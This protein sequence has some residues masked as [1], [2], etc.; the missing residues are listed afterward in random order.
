MCWRQRLTATF[1]YSIMLHCVREQAAPHV[2]KAQKRRQA[3]EA[4]EAERER[5]IAE[6]LAEM[7][8]SERA[9][10]EQSLAQ[11]LQPLGLALREIPVSALVPVHASC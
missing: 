9:L 10:E 7:G 2:S 4:Q 6:E 11:L 3:R 5:R 1:Q 8:D